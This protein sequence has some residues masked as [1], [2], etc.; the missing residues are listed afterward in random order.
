MSDGVVKLKELLFDVETQTLAD[1][2]SRIDELT[3][4]GRHERTALD[5]RIAHLASREAGFRL[6]LSSRLDEVFARAGTLERFQ[7]S[8]AEVLDKALRDAEVARHGELSEA[9]APLV[10]RTIK[11]EIRNSK[12][13]LVEALYPMT[14]RM[15]QAYVA[16]AIK[17]MMNEINRRLGE[18]PTMLRL[19]A[20]TSGR[21]VAELAL[22]ESQRLDVDEIY[23]V[24]RGTGELVD[25]WPPDAGGGNRGHMMSG[26]LSAINEFATEAFDVK[27]PGLRRLD[28]GED[29][30]Y[31]RASPT[32]LLAAK[33]KGTA[34][35]SVE[36]I[37]DAEFLS[38][39]DTRFKS[40]PAAA[41]GSGPDDGDGTP[42]ETALATFAQQLEQRIVS[43]QEELRSGG[44]NP[45]KLLL[46]L[47]AL[48][49]AALIGWWAYATFTT[50]RTR[51]LARGVIESSEPMRGYPVELTVA[52]YGES[53]AVSGL[54]PS[55]EAKSGLIAG[56]KAALP[57]VPV[58]DGLTVV[59]S[60]DARIKPE[61]DRL[62]EEVTGLSENVPPEV[63]RLRNEVSDLRTV[64]AREAAARAVLR[65]TS[66]LSGVAPELDRLAA[67]EPATGE[68]GVSRSTLPAAV[69][70]TVRSLGNL[71]FQDATVPL[72]AMAD[73][74]DEARAGL[75]DAIAAL[76]SRTSPIAAPARP[77]ADATQPDSGRLAESA[78]ALALEAERF[79]TLVIA[80]D[81]ASA[82]RTPP[83]ALPAPTERDR[84]EAFAR[85]NAIFFANGTEFRDPQAARAVMRK[86][87]ET[88]RGGK[89]LVRVV[90]YTDEQGARQSN[91][92]LAQDRAQVVYDELIAL[93]M[94]AERLSVIGRADG[95]MLS[96]AIGETSPNRRVQFEVGFDGE[97]AQ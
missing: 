75:G 34:H 64:M 55:P 12:D 44:F 9:I 80:M 68:T 88:A 67:A 3:V 41:P 17:D 62:R 49:L 30:V 60:A 1:L 58:D 18:N 53:I 20:W 43:R 50:E 66:R 23:L 28:I 24:R 31:L 4:S 57:G 10:T 39:L 26:I 86:L 59:A 85:A 15:V 27:G 38:A 21:S 78:E 14:G 93:G 7:S 46:W 36:K 77:S 92:V 45:A 70:A 42:A 48:S 56:L 89:L 22:L 54:T 13:D 83:I 79:A 69:S 5:E 6:E 51:S 65:A 2:Q 11:T 29:Q 74:I 95:R 19:R 35:A 37:I 97:R 33:C 8:V 76:S 82:V 90:G 25:H 81:Q 40:E 61:V 94:P 47:A 87:A 71:D 91:M 52:P 16:S 63:S 32:F 84:L 73:R 96:R 72:A